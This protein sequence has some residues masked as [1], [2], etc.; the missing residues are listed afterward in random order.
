MRSFLRDLRFAARGLFRQPGFAL[1]AVGTLALGIGANATVFSLVNAV[2][3]RPLPYPRSEDLYLLRGAQPALQTENAPIS[4]PNFTDLRRASSFEAVAISKTALFNLT[5]GR[6]VERVEGARVSPELLS[7]L[8][9]RPLLGRGF[10][11]AEG[12]AGGP[13]VVV[14]GHGFWQRRF[15][16]DRAMVG[17]T[18]G[19]D[20][21]RYLVAGILPPRLAYP[22]PETDLWIPY[23]PQK[24]DELRG[25]NSLRAVARMRSGVTAP[26]ANAELEVIGRRLAEQYAYTNAGW[27][28]RLKPL[29]EELVG[30]SRKALW[31]LQVA[32]AVLLG[33]ACVNVANLLLVRA[34]GRRLELA[35]RSALGAGRRR[36]V[37]QFLTESLLLG[38]AGGATGVSLAAAAGVL[39]R[40]L[41]AKI[42]P[43]ADEIS[44][45]VRVLIFGLAVSVGTALLF[46]IAPA[47]RSGGRTLGEDLKSG[48]R[49]AT[50]GV[51]DHRALR[52]LVISEVA[53]ALV[54]TA[55]AGLLLTSFLRLKH[56]PPGFD[57]EGLWTASVGLA[58][59]RYPDPAKQVRYYREA[60]ERLSAIRGIQSAA[61][62]G[63][64]PLASFSNSTSFVVQG[65]PVAEG[66]EPNAD[67]VA[68]TPDYFATLRIPFVV[69]RAFTDRD[70][71]QAPKVVL[72]NQAMARLHWPGESPIGRRVQLYGDE[73]MWREVVGIVGDVRLRGLEEAA[74]P[75]LYVPLPQNAFAPHLKTASFLARLSPGTAATALGEARSAL[76]RVDPEQAVSP[77][78][79]MSAVVSDSL[80]PRR[81]NVHVT[82]VFGSLAAALAAVGIS[83]VMAHAVAQRRQEIGIRMALGADRA[84]V[85][86][87]VL[88]EGGALAAIGVAAGLILSIPC[89]R[90]LS[91]ALFGVSP[92]NLAVYASVSVIILAIS[93]AAIWIPARRAAAVDPLSALQAP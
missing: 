17:R 62:V 63:R 23:Q 42:L 85:L 54:L 35:I 45:D 51:G 24:S 56:V 37:R 6:S 14:L 38:V 58:P 41:P 5:E 32:A 65:R 39:L 78:R 86:R 22:A 88:K 43:R 30:G 79:P 55:G 50:R 80:S 92:G 75:T 27:V 68:A 77:F 26:R 4:Y 40:R 20:G 36:I 29:R 90:L 15:G 2:L 46:G 61:V 1:V 10:T 57:P 87:L 71:A 33:I 89:S 84:S 28:F 73:P 18:I 53:L 16:G 13:D 47:L 83:G 12:E 74:N 60:L 34:A 93:T 66:N 31:I 59:G 48:R 25:N 8:R 67:Y 76:A 19:L 7:V 3:L 11:A 69:G 21:R 64:I 70:D 49:G 81:L 44:L 91:G 52:L 9:A 72:V 82:L